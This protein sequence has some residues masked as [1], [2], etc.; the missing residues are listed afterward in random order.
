MTDLILSNYGHRYVNELLKSNSARELIKNPANLILLQVLKEKKMMVGSDEISKDLIRLGF[1]EKANGRSMDE[2]E[3]KYKTNPLENVTGLVFEFTRACNFNCL[4]CRNGNNNDK[5][6]PNIEKLKHIADQFCHINVKRFDFIGGEVTKYGN[7]WLELSHYINRKNNKTITVYTSGWWLE[8]TNFEAAGKTYSNDSEYLLDLKGNGV[9]HILFSIDG[10]E[11]MHD[12]TRK[13]KGLFQRIIHS[14]ERV[15]HAGLK[16]RISAMI[17]DNLDMSTANAFADIATRMYDGMVGLSLQQKINCMT[18]DPSNHFSNF[19]DIGNGIA[20]KSNKHKIDDIPKKLLHCKGYYRP[21]PNLRIMAN[22]NLSVCP[23]LDAGEGFGNIKDQDI[24]SI[25]NNMQ[26]SSTYQLHAKKE[27]GNYLQ[28][29]DRTVFGEH[30]DHI[31]SIRVILTLLARY[32]EN[33]GNTEPETI[34][35][36]NEWVA[37]KSGHLK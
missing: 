27:I 14:F 6:L 34:R 33:A 20:L 2:I 24:L 29:L 35:K 4:H 30:Y 3:F 21:S 25:L 9:T 13:H 15:K 18:N 11:E 16:P 17:K 10:D 37:S 5:T 8:K 19:I 36:A 1:L 31:C 23:L 28:Y 12:R 7:G 26:Q 32:I 22:G